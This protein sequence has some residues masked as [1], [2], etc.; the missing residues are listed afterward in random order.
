MGCMAIIVGVLFFIPLFFFIMQ[1]YT[2]GINIII[3][4]LIPTAIMLVFLAI[5]VLLNK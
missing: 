4:I 1:L 5:L 2:L 3:S